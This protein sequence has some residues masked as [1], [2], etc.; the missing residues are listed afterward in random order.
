VGFWEA[1]DA[2]NGLGADR[3]PLRFIHVSPKPPRTPDRYFPADHPSLLSLVGGLVV[4][5]GL[6]ADGLHVWLG[7]AIRGALSAGVLVLLLKWLY[8]PSRRLSG[9]LAAK[10]LT[11]RAG[12]SDPVTLILRDGR[13]VGARIQAGWFVRA[14]ERGVDAREAVD[15]R[16]QSRPI[17]ASGGHP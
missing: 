5:L 3:W 16:A 13:Q 1:M 6:L 2:F 10:A 17:E 14:T 4:A 15:V 8:R 9:E 11:V 12:D 7:A